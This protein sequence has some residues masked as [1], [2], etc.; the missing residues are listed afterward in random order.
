MRA[1]IILKSGYWEGVKEP[2]QLALDVTCSA[3]SVQKQHLPSEKG[4]YPGSGVSPDQ[5]LALLR[6]GIKVYG[7]A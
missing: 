3:I 2:T 7:L 1:G 5:L 6:R 4:T